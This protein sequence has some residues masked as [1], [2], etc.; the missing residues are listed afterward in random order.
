MRS[1]MPIITASNK[2]YSPQKISATYNNSS[3][4]L[5]Q[6]H[7]SPAG[8][9]NSLLIDAKHNLDQV[10]QLTKPVAVG[11]FHLERMRADAK[12]AL[13]NIG[14]PNVFMNTKDDFTDV[15]AKLSGKD[16]R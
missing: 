11:A 9:Y 8:K 6:S 15:A 14:V 5:P 3:K 16:G 7:P 4:D 13:D 2:E 10:G 1:K 12:S